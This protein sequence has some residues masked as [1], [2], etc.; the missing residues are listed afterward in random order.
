MGGRKIGEG[1]WIGARM[2]VLMPVEAG[3][4]GFIGKMGRV[5]MEL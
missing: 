3:V 2:P 5:C 4:R 1:G